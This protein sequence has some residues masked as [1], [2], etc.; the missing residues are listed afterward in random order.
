MLAKY[1]TYYEEVPN[2][3]SNYRGKLVSTFVIIYNI[4]LLKNDNF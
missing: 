1:Y 4:L 3:A 2:A